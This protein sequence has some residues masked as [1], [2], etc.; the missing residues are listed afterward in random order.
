[1]DLEHLERLARVKLTGESREKL[2]GQL[3]RIIEFVKQLQGIDTAGIEPRIQAA[4]LKPPLRGDETKPCLPRDEVLVASP[5]NRK[6][7]FAVPP[8]IEA[9]EL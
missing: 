9:D 7:Y 4:G 2:R 3:A 6:G 1:M 8:V 5:E